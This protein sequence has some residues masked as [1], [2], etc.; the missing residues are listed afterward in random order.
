MLRAFV[1]KKSSY[2]S[3]LHLLHYRHSSYAREWWQIFSWLM[4]VSVT[5]TVVCAFR[6][7]CPRSTEAN[8]LHKTA[9]RHRI[10]MC[11]LQRIDDLLTGNMWSSQNRNDNSIW[12]HSNN[13]WHCFHADGDALRQ[14]FHVWRSAIHREWPAR[15]R[16]QCMR[17][18]NHTLINE[19]INSSAWRARFERSVDIAFHSIPSSVDSVETAA[20]HHHQQLM[21]CLHVAYAQMSM[22]VC[23]Q[24]SGALLTI[25]R[26]SRFML[27]PIECGATTIE[28]VAPLSPLRHRARR[29]D[30]TQRNARCWRWW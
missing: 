4:P 7:F 2:G 22:D 3:S 12:I 19:Q 6:V 15:T 1:C 27:I 17:T 24:T 23:A 29:K 30:A 5:V 20:T 28:I 18:A 26:D 10:I 25:Q 14:L 13:R 9:A 8:R 11:R 16:S 21:R